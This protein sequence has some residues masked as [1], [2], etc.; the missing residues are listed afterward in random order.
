MTDEQG[1][2]FVDGLRVTTD[3]LNHL[4]QSAQQ[5]VGDLRRVVGLGHI[6]YGL[7]ILISA[8]GAS[9][10]LSPGLAFTP[11]GHRLA[12]DEGA[13]LT[14]P[15]GAGPFSVVLSASSHDDPTTRFDNTGTIIFSDT[16]ITVTATAPTD[17][18]SLV[19]GTITLAAG[20]LT[21]AQD[22]A[23]FMAPASHGHSGDFFQDG[24][25]V[26]RFD[27]VR[28]SG[29][30]V[31]G[32]PGPPGPPGA[33]GQPGPPGPQGANGQTGPAGV[34][35]PPG[36][37]GPAGPQGEAGPQGGVGSAG[38]P[39]PQGPAGP[40]G[41]TGPQGPEG[42]R[43]PQGPPGG[44][45]HP[46]ILPTPTPF[47]P[48]IRPPAEAQAAFEAHAVATIEAL[49]WDPRAPIAVVD[50]MTLLQNLQLTFTEALGEANAFLA[51]SVWVRFCPADPGAQRRATIPS[52]VGL[53]GTPSIADRVLGWGMTESSTRVQSALSKGGL[54]LVDV[55]CDYLEDASGAPVSGS[56]AALAGIPASGAPGGIFRTWIQVSAG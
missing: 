7:R 19:V 13:A 38:P 36:P 39:G 23:L 51:H 46:P 35:G 17:P 16:S 32:P 24:A 55:D 31:T 3:H 26:W 34:S 18:E 41:M 40:I 8:D 14:L 52:I 47:R 37:A 10:T 30:D 44:T 50:A 33:N 20:T 48:P 9:A 45:I 2:V 53:H 49:N 54:I 28:L 22:P 29:T 5:A 11:A 6:G 25:G 27:G 1:T 12:V 21:A 43:G 4:E 56:G 42:P 15:A